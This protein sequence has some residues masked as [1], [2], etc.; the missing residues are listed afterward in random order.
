MLYNVSRHADQIWPYTFKLC[1]CALSEFDLGDSSCHPLK[2]ICH[3]LNYWKVTCTHKKPSFELL[4]KV[5]QFILYKQ[6]KSFE[7]KTGQLGMPQKGHK[8]KTQV[9]NTTHLYP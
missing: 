5:S 2:F 1:A 3:P 6:W 7:Q 9:S 4:E 8:N